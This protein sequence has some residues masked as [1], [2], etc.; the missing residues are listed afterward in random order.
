MY[1]YLMVW[2]ISVYHNAPSHTIFIRT[3]I[4][5][6]SICFRGTMPSSPIAIAGDFPLSS[7][8][9][10]PHHLNA[11][12]ISSCTIMG[13]LWFI[14]SLLQLNTFPLVKASSFCSL[15][16]LNNVEVNHATGNWMGCQEYM[17]WW[18]EFS[19][20]TLTKAKDFYKLKD[21]LHFRQ[22]LFEVQVRT[23][24]FFWIRK[25]LHLVSC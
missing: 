16:R 14:G 9:W 7:V 4:S 5:S 23:F 21:P 17:W 20:T 13:K 22:I 11:L 18:G 15:A 2:H 12:R 24:R 10:L 1:F 6:T 25:N 19:S 8:P 3:R